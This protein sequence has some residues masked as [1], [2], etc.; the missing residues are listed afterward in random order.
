MTN[1]FQHG[2]TRIRGRRLIERLQAATDHQPD[3]R[4]TADF[5]ARERA[6]HRAVAQTDYAVRAPLD[7]AQPMCDENNRH[8]TLLQ[9]VDD[10]QQTVRL[11]GRQARRGLVHDD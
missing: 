5:L 9:P 11:G 2:C 6:D 4:V 8:A 10:A 7:L 1:E 3:H